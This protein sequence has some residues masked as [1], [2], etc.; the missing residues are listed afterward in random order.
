METINW[1]QKTVSINDINPAIYNPRK[2]NKK[3]KDAF[4]RNIEKYGIAE[5]IVIN[6]NNTIIGGHMRYYIYQ[7]QGIEELDVFY[8]DRLLNDREEKELNIL[9]N[10]V[11]GYTDAMKLKELGLSKQVLDELG[12]RDF[13]IPEIKIKD[14][15]VVVAGTQKNKN[16]YAFFFEQMDII[17]AKRMVKM[18]MERENLPSP[19]DA[20]Y[21]LLKQYA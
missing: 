4:V 14:I 11:S 3:A 19:A 5:P 16:I 21:F 13:K 15:D 2:I 9:L 18:I 10:S 12:F 1:K 7:Q 17:Y 8:P 6:A 20:I